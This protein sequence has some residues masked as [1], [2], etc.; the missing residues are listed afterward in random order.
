MALVLV[1]NILDLL[2]NATLTP[3]TWLLSG[4]LLGYAEYL[5]RGLPDNTSSL[6]RWR[7][8]MR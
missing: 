2:P 6:T 7:P 8:I 3:L 4:A 1:I 5:K